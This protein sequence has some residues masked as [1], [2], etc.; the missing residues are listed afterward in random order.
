MFHSV[1]TWADCE[2][3]KTGHGY[4]HRLYTHFPQSGVF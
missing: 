2:I 4:V 3:N 1:L